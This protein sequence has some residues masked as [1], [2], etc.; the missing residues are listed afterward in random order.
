M[1]MEIINTHKAKTRLSQILDKVANGK[2]VIITKNGN[3]VA[4]L[5]PYSKLPKKRTPGALRGKIIIRKDFDE[6]VYRT[7]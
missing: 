6:P 1:Y 4:M 5:S 3:P 7:H 2:K